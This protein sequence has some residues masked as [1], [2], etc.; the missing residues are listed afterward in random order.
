MKSVDYVLGVRKVC[1][2]CPP[3]FWRWMM[4]KILNHIA[5]NKRWYLIG[6]AVASLLS[7]FFPFSLEIFFMGDVLYVKQNIISVCKE[8]LNTT[9]PTPIFY[10]LIASIVGSISSIIIL[11]LSNKIKFSL[12][13]N[14]L[15]WSFIIAILSSTT[16]L[17]GVKI[18]KPYYGFYFSFLFALLYLIFFLF[19][20]EQK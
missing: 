1:P 11:S 12:I 3:Y 7:L 10:F 6:C 2:F 9:I 16:N 4:R 17:I 18:Y 5:R 20:K 15:N 13:G 8:N 14:I 19:F